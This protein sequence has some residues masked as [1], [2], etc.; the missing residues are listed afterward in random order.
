MKKK[1]QSTMRPI[2]STTARHETFLLECPSTTTSGETILFDGAR[3]PAAINHRQRKL[4]RTTTMDDEDNAKASENS[5]SRAG[6]A[7]AAVATIAAQP[8]PPHNAISDTE[9]SYEQLT[10]KHWLLAASPCYVA[11]TSSSSSVVSRNRSCWPRTDDPLSYANEFPTRPIQRRTR[12]THR[13]RSNRVLISSSSVRSLFMTGLLVLLV[14]CLCLGNVRTVSA[15]S[16][17]HYGHNYMHSDHHGHQRGAGAV[18]GDGL[19]RGCKWQR[20]SMAIADDGSAVT[21]YHDID[22]ADVSDDLSSSGVG[23]DAAKE[24]LSCKL[25][26]IESLD[27]LFGNLST[28]Q[29]ERIRALRLE[30]NDALFYES[31]LAQNAVGGGGV[32]GGPLL[33]NLR[34]LQELQIEY[35]KIRFVPS[36]VLS[37][38]VDLH[39]FSV[40]THNSDWSAMNLEFHRDSFV[41]LVNLN[42]LDLTENNIWT[43]PNDVF[44]PM[45]TLRFLNLS[46]NRLTDIAHLGFSDW[47]KG[48]TAPGRSCNTG[49]E[50]LDLSANSITGL[51]DN[52]FS[53]LRLLNSLFLQDN[54]LTSLADRSF[55]GLQSLKMVN[56][57]NNKLTALPPELFQSPR[58]LQHIYLKNNSLNVLAPGLLE[59]LDRLEVLDLSWNKLTSEWVKRNTFAGLVR[60][61]VLNLDHNQL[62]RI[63]QNVFRGLYSLQILNME[64]NN[65]ETIADYAFSDLKNLHALTLSQNRLKELEAFHFSD[66]YVLNQLQL[67]RNEIKT[68]HE[69]AFENITQLQDLALNDNYLEEIPNLARLKFLKTLDLGKNRI[70]SVRNES[71][72]GLEQL[73]GLRLTDNLITNISRDAFIALSSLHVLNLASNR[74][75]HVDQSAFISNPTLKAIRLDNNELEDISSVFTSL[76]SL[77]W[78]NVSDNR[79]R[80]FDYSHF[81]SSLDWLDMHRN[82][83]SE[84]GNFFDV[85]NNLQI[86]MLDISHNKLTYIRDSSIPNSIETIFLNNNEIESVDPGTFL[87]KQFLQKVVLFGNRLRKLEIAALA[88]QPFADHRDIPQFYMGSNPFHCDCNMEWLQRI[89]DLTYLRQ[90]PH[91]ADLDQIQCTMEHNR[92][93]AVRPLMDIHASEFL[94]KYESHCFAL[95]HCCEFDACDCK[96]TCPDRCSCYHDHSWSSNIVDCGNLDY[97]EI[98]HKIPMDATAI[99]LDGNN[100][101][102]MASHQF[103]GKKKLETLFLNGSNI[104]S[105]HNGTFNGVAGLKVL[106]LESNNLLEVRGPELAQLTNLRTI[107][108]DNN[109]MTSLGSHTF[110]KMKF[111]ESLSLSGNQVTGFDLWQQLGGAF[112]SGSLNQLSFDDSV[113]LNCECTALLKFRDWQKFIASSE[114]VNINNFACTGQTTTLGQAMQQCLN[115][116]GVNGAAGREVTGKNVVY[117]SNGGE[118]TPNVQRTVLYSDKSG[119]ESVSGLLGGGYV[120][121]I[122]AIVAALIGTALLLT[123]VCVF[124]QDVRVWAHNKYGVRFFRDPETIAARVDQCNNKDKLYDAYMVYNIRDSEFA[125][126]IVAGELQHNGYALF[127]HHRDIHAAPFLDSMHSVA[128]ISRKIIIVAS[129]NFVHNEWQQPAFRMALQTLLE[130]VPSAQRRHKFVVI[131]TAPPELVVVDH[132]MQILLR[133]CSVICWGERRFWAKLRY[134]LPDIPRQSPATRQLVLHQNGMH[135]TL[136]HHN[137]HNHHHHVQQQMSHLHQMGGQGEN[138]HAG[139]CLPGKMTKGC[140]TASSSP[141]GPQ[142][143]LMQG[144]T[145]GRNAT[146]NLR[147]TPAPTTLDSW[148]KL[149]QPGMIVPTL[150]PTGTMDSRRGGYQQ[151]QQQQQLQQSQQSVQPFSPFHPRNVKNSSNHNTHTKT[152]PSTASMISN[153]DPEDGRGA[154][155]EDTDGDDRS[156]GSSQHYEAPP[157][158]YIPTTAS[159]LGHVY[160]TIPETTTSSGKQSPLI[161]ITTNPVNLL[162]LNGNSDLDAAAAAKFQSGG[163]TMN[164]L[165]STGNKILSGGNDNGRAYFV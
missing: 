9:R 112:A 100:F 78:L 99:Y 92:G 34:R 98:P 49:L 111:L 148:C 62:T 20:L 56:M 46:I 160:S 164:N 12:S 133:T 147:Y 139:C 44:C 165:N 65:I 1:N 121:L 30:C 27:S 83:I 138:C 119:G 102:N 109:R 2:L 80:W 73:V 31:S 146:T 67:D 137:L 101:G 149:T 11:S 21:N 162:H 134:L 143:M 25:R 26:T 33:S 15:A 24:V 28:L 29:T 64:N 132:L 136:P 16:P 152:S 158:M 66:L 6:A 76:T 87:N 103:I 39:K 144:N 128:D 161:G 155:D 131:L 38:L 4:P 142:A 5:Y 104:N 159:S 96:M 8:F 7:A 14:L 116:A 105:I 151:Q 95:C 125:Q 23:S 86:K 145:V 43:L 22:A 153:T 140:C 19:P 57:T 61:V 60:L 55:V 94:C 79:L 48:P 107:N 42:V 59:G 53:S 45:T 113:Q 63:D 163:G 110:T 141:V 10:T 77:V 150:E 90:H 70:R 82:N 106:H 127:L 41:G 75:K 123:L 91:V 130:S 13:S 54:H 93:P 52:G 17:G 88:L 122:S 115:E 3:W 18:S 74:I 47:G 108:L 81:P 114:L 51:P 124:R 37:S 120:P 40:R 117:V 32:A 85:G 35:C 135:N 154:D 157:L 71:F 156:T 72:E 36:R 126:Q 118:T 69:R 50:V 129:L 68:V 97:T 89:N 84:L 58:A